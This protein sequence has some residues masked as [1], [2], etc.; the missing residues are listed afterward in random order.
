MWVQNLTGSLSAA[1]SATQA[2]FRP[3][4][5]SSHCAT[6]VVLPYPAGAAI[7]VSGHSMTDRSRVSDET[8]ATHPLRP[9][10]GRMQLRFQERVDA[11]QRRLALT[12]AGPLHDSLRRSHIPARK[13]IRPPP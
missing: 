5:R 13:S 3:V 11:R 12:A 10:A 4:I 7:R 8:I 6:T 9:H 2:R 1:S